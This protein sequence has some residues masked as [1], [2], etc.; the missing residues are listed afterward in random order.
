MRSVCRFVAVVILGLMLVAPVHQETA[1]AYDSSIVIQMSSATKVLDLGPN[2]N[3]WPADWNTVA[4]DDSIWD[5][6]VPVLGATADCVHTAL[7]PLGGLP[8]FYGPN[9]QDFYLFRTRFTVSEAQSY[10]GSTLIYANYD[11]PPEYVQYYT[12]Q[13]SN[14]LYLNGSYVADSLDHSLHTLSVAA[15]LKPGAN[16]LAFWEH[17]TSSNDCDTSVGFRITIRMRGVKGTPPLPKPTPPIGPA[18][19]LTFPADKAI[20]TGTGLPLAWKPF[21]RAAA[22]LVHVW[23]VKADPGQAITA[24][25]VATA[26]STVLATRATIS[27]AN[28][29]KGTY[30]WSVAALNA[31][32]QI[33]TGWAAARSVQLE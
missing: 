27:T 21:P 22:Y 32:G 20:V 14:W 16:V 23:L 33:I 11:H 6:A 24:A 10:E 7:G 3:T 15:Q 4:F 9:A 31:G 18:V 28:M 17:K 29:P 30:L 26:A 2:N 1:R 8:L 25:T 13:H 12:N 19:A 5:H